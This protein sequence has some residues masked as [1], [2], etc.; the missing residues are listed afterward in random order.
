[1]ITQSELKEILHYDENTG[2]FTWLIK[3][4]KNL[5][6]GAIAG[7][8]RPDGYIQIRIKGKLYLAHRL[9]WLYVFGEFPKNEVDHFNHIKND[10]SINN[11]RDVSGG[12]NSQ[13]QV[14]A[15]KS[16]KTTGLSGSSF[17]KRDGVYRA[18]I[19]VNKKYMHI[20]YFKTAIEAHEAYLIAKRRL[21]KG[22]TL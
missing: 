18:S 22:N 3:P 15:Q 2:V 16:N 1:M 21:H 10:N 7:T 13:N 12:V 8:H 20:G 6:I 14:K 9:A 11:L 17:D 19:T 4:C 5:K